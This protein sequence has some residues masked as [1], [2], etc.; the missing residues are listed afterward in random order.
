LKCDY[1]G[2]DKTLH[3]IPSPNS[4]DE[5]PW[6]VCESCDEVLDMQSLQSM[7]SVMLELPDIPEDAKD[8]IEDDYKKVNEM[9]KEKG[10]TTFEIRRME[11]GYEAKKIGGE[12]DGFED[13][14]EKR[15]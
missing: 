7:R 14:M 8:K 4:N 2:E 5:K 10:A 11:S 15:S 1:C 12:K 9:L 3:E 6:N 13:K